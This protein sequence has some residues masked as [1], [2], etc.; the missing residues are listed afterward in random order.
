MEEEKKNPKIA[1]ETYMDRCMCQGDKHFVLCKFHPKYIR[2]PDIL[3]MS[4]EESSMSS[5]DSDDIKIEK[6]NKG[7]RP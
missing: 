4:S 1:E 5:D 7:G 6:K 2:Q 3:M